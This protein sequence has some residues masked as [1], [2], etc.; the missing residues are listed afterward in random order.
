[1]NVSEQIMV[2][3]DQIIKVDEEKKAYLLDATEI[4]TERLEVLMQGGK[5]TG[6]EM[7]A[8]TSVL[9][10]LGNGEAADVREALLQE[11]TACTRAQRSYLRCLMESSGSSSVEEVLRRYHIFMDG[12]ILCTKRMGHFLDRLLPD[13]ERTPD[14]HKISIPVSVVRSV[15]EMSQIPLLDMSEGAENIARLQ[16]TD[17]LVVRGDEQ[18]RTTLSTFISAFSKFKPDHALVLIT[19]DPKLANAIATLNAIGIEGEDI[20]VLK[21][22]ENGTAALWDEP[23][24]VE[25]E[26]TFCPQETAVD[27]DTLHADTDWVQFD[28]EDPGVTP[29]EEEVW[30][31]IIVEDEAP[32]EELLEEIIVEDEAPAEELLKEIIVEDEAPA[33]EL[34]EE[35]IVEDEAPAEELL[36]E[37]IVEDEAPAEELLEEII[38]EDEAPAEELLE[39]I[40]VEDEA[41]AEE[42]LEE[43]IV[44][45][46]APAEEPLE[47]IIVEDENPVE[48]PAMEHI[49]ADEL[50][51]LDST[52]QVDNFGFEKLLRETAAK[53]RS[54]AS[55]AEA[56]ERE[57][58][59]PE[60][61][62]MKQ[63]LQ[64]S[65]EQDDENEELGED[66]LKQF[67]SIE[68][69][70]ESDED[71]E[72]SFDDDDDLDLEFQ[73]DDQLEKLIRETLQQSTGAAQDIPNDGALDSDG[74]IVL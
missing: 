64:C 15:E 62:E 3:F 18:D 42:L 57:E 34:L 5:P 39:E 73:D 19:G 72:L 44:E 9:H 21:L 17:Q 50:F 33:E 25:L 7:L 66:A 41:P 51:R 59:D 65:D 27:T 38:V 2:R 43:I 71:E 11:L 10:Y 74:W 31:E 35:I 14:A 68:I 24:A 36:E 70:T 20:L 67:M 23:D 69:D 56:A 1:M 26:K 55:V 47:E 58:V 60:V 45:D 4:G 30:E 48:E 28:D 40:I 63:L 32:A 61:E 8:I 29:S 16:K 13:L 12:S 22:R 46:E 37:I 6:M 53:E 54:K 49:D 52:L